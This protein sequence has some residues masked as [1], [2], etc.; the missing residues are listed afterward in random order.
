M[1]ALSPFI[2]A[3]VHIFVALVADHAATI[4]SR[5]EHI[6]LPRLIIWRQFAQPTPIVIVAF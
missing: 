2:S 3:T 5:S 1:Y 4:A 6:Y